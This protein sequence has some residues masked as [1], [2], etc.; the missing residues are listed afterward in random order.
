MVGIP[1][2]QFWNMGLPELYLA[3]EGYMEFNSSQ[4][5]KPMNKDELE[6]LMELYPD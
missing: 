6:D 3:I 2:E 5:D 4:K 1:P